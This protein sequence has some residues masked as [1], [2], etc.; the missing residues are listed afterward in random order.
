MFIK[1][2]IN[3]YQYAKESLENYLNSNKEE[4]IKKRIKE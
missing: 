3:L 1:F 4:N 2:E